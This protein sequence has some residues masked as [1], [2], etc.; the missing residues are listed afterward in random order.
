MQSKFV[1]LQLLP[2]SQILI[3]LF[4]IFRILLLLLLLLNKLCHGQVS[5]LSSH[6]TRMGRDGWRSDRVEYTYYA[7][8]VVFFLSFSPVLTLLYV[9]SSRLH[10]KKRIKECTYG[11]SQEAHMCAE[12]IITFL[13]CGLCHRDYPSVS[14]S[15][16]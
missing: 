5:S 4:L 2:S 3:L 14:C 8:P 15:I 13:T 7:K 1:G 16:R 6:N 9:W 10:E 12:Y 11:S